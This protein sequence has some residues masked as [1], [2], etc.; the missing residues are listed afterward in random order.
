MANLILESIPTDAQRIRIH[1]AGDFFSQAYFDAWLMVARSR[2]D[3]AFYAYTKSIPFWIHH[4]QSDLP[5]NF[6]LNASLRSL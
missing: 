4:R 1:V 2:P 3:I 5:E 6:K